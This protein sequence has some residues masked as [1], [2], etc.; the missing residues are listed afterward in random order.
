MF[1]LLSG[2][3]LAQHLGGITQLT[4]LL[5]DDVTVLINMH[6]GE[7]EDR[8]T[9]CKSGESTQEAK[10]TVQP[11]CPQISKGHIYVLGCLFF[12][13]MFD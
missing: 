1:V 5:A 2:Q 12:Q 8:F 11:S 4:S 10:T 3:E 6:L 9:L 13:C 7:V